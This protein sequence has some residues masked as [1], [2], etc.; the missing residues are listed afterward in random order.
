MLRKLWNDSIAFRRITVALSLGLAVLIPYL[1]SNIPQS[2]SLPDPAIEELAAAHST[3]RLRIYRPRIDVGQPVLSFEGAANVN[4]QVWV[5]DATL[6]G[7]SVQFFGMHAPP[8][9]VRAVYAKGSNQKNGTE[10]CRTTLTV[11]R[12]DHSSAPQALD[13]WQARPESDEQSFRQVIVSSPETALMVEVSTNSPRPDVTCRQVLILGNTTIPIPG[14]PV[15]LVAPAN[16]KVTLQFSSVD[17]IM[18]ASFTKGNTFDHLSVGDGTL[19]ADGFD[20]ISTG[21]PDPPL[22]HVLAHKGTNGITL[23]D[24][25]LGAEEVRLS[26][27]EK[28]ERADAWANGKRLLVFDLVGWIQKNPV[29]GYVLAAVLIPGFWAWIRKACFPAKPGRETERKPEES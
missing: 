27:G 15:Y 26:V 4:A 1:A 12:A 7:S 17:S 14:V 20:V 23:Q 5:D 13:L 19:T 24:L 16:K 29:F 10:D 21:K 8:H 18:P 6:T 25:K 9:P 22:L 28:T 2:V 3:E 11:R